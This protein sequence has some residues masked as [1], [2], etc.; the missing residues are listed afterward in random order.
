MVT[1]AKI[2]GAF[3]MFL[4]APALALSPQD[5]M[6]PDRASCYARSYSKD[7]LAKHPAQQVTEIAVKPDFEI[8]DP[9]LGLRLWLRL[10]GVPGG[11]FE[12]FAY[13]ENE[14]GSTLYCGLE[15]DA[16]AFVVTPAKG[17][18][19]LVEVGRYGMSFE[20]AAGFVTLERDQG[21]DRSFLLHPASCN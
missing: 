5:Q 8:A 11:T 16:G 20:N 17:G 1:K 4:S 19:I 12:G 21:D 6:F 13:C 10:R 18:S 14:G 15:G 2:C 7:H 9:M 3:L